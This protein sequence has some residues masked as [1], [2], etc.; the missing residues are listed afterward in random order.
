MPIC[1]KCGIDRIIRA[2][3]LCNTCYDKDRKATI[4]SQKKIL[5]E[6]P[7]KPKSRIAPR[8]MQHMNPETIIANWDKILKAAGF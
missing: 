4:E 3:G 7:P 8:L 5:A 2:R 6:T 1:K